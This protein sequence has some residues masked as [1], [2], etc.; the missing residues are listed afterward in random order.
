MVLTSIRFWKFQFSPL[1]IS[2]NFDFY[3]YNF[4]LPRPTLSFWVGKRVKLEIL[5][6]PSSVEFWVGPRAYVSCYNLGVKF[7]KFKNHT[8]FTPYSCVTRY[9]GMMGSTCHPYPSSFPGSL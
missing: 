4:I 8:K 9:F 7:Q 6:K 3:D 1:I 5:R 2:F